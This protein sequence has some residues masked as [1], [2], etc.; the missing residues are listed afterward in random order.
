MIRNVNGSGE[1]MHIRF[2]FR[3]KWQEYLFCIWREYR[4]AP[5]KIKDTSYAEILFK[6]DWPFRERR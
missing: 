5:Y 3:S 6:I 1:S 4:A 2:G